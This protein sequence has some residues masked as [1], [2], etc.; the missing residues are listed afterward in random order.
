MKIKLLTLMILAISLFVIILNFVSAEIYMWNSIIIDETDSITRYH[1]YYQMEDTSEGFRWRTKDIPVTF[2]YVVEALPYSLIGGSIDWCNFTII[3]FHNIYDKEGF[4]LNTSLET[5]NVY[6]GTGNLSTGEITINV[7]DADD[8]TADMDCHYTNSTTLYQDHALIGRFDTIVPS[9]ECKGCD[10]FTLEELSD[11]IE[12]NEQTTQ[13]E[14]TIYNRI[15]TLVDMNF[16]LWLYASWLVKLFFL[17]FSVSLIFSSVYFLY[18][19]F[20]DIARQI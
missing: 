16:T 10:D 5:Q 19:F 13:N 17:I 20:E 3:A 1:A 4:Q 2:N 7:K 14:L 11:E 12:R 8:I 6:F 15:Q 18:K 9:F